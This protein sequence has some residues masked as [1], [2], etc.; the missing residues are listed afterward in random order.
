M[1]PGSEFQGV[2]R[3]GRIELD[4][5]VHWPDGTRVIVSA[6]RTESARDV[7]LGEVIIAGFGLA[8]RS[9]ADT[10]DHLGGRCTIVEKNPDT[11]ETQRSLGR[12][13]L[14]GDISDESVLEAAGIGSADALAL[15]VPDE[16]A[17]LRAIEV[18]RRLNPEIYIIARTMYAS[19]GIKAI[20]LGADDVIKSEQT[21]AQ[22]FR[23]KLVRRLDRRSK[24]TG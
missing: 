18:A 10:V 16:E 23:E 1:T 4:D 7:E 6:A 9:V 5:P 24:A 12:R 19:R 15:T 3:D 8:G 22:Q 20:E 2:I 17:V 11:V 21:V 14:H 13:I